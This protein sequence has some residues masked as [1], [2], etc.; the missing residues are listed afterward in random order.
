MFLSFLTPDQYKYR[1]QT[2]PLAPRPFLMI[3]TLVSDKW[4]LSAVGKNPVEPRFEFA[5]P[6]LTVHNATRLR[7]SSLCQ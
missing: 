3:H 1:I 6:E 4:L 2:E 7:L 5:T